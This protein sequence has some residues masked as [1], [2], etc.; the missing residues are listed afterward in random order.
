MGS[1]INWFCEKTNFLVATGMAAWMGNATDF[2]SGMANGAAAMFALNKGG[3]AAAAYSLKWLQIQ[4][5]RL[6]HSIVA[7]QWV[8]ITRRACTPRPRD[9]NGRS[10]ET[11][12]LIIYCTLVAHDK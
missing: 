3:L 2:I 10:R 9:M 7:C 4:L 8:P 6:H 5:I 11:T 12:A 1:S